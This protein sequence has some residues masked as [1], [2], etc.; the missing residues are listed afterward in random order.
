MKV[1]YLRT[2][3]QKQDGKR[4]NFAKLKREFDKVYFDHGKSGMLPLEQRKEASQMLKDLNDGK[5]TSLTIP[6]LSRFGRSSKDVI[7]DLAHFEDKNIQITIQDIKMDRLMK[8]GTVN[9]MWR[10]FINIFSAVAEMERINILERMKQGREAFIEAGGTLGRP[11]GAKET[12]QTFV[13][14]PRNQQIAKFLRMGKKYRDIEARLDCSTSTISKVKKIMLTPK[15][16]QIANLLKMGR[17]YKD[18]QK[19]LN[20]STNTISNVKLTLQEA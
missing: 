13:E 2:S 19:A 16:E 3:T 14:K 9:P 11:T 8:D 4:F 10:M 5:I 18:I 15:N 12:I 17:S 1:I 7:N 20:C 6:E